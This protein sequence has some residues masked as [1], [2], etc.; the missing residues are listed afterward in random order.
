MEL[1]R[2]NLFW[3][4]QK[5]LWERQKVLVTFQKAP[6]LRKNIVRGSG[7]KKSM[8]VCVGVLAAVI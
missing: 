2:F 5:T 8:N 3:R 7:L 4:E 6:S 1:R